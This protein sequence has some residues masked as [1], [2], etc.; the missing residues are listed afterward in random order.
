MGDFCWKSDRDSTGGNMTEEVLISVKGLHA[1]ATEDED[2]VE[3]FSAGKY[4]F[5]NGKHYI[6]YEEMFCLEYHKQQ[7]H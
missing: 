6:L 7:H 5:K 1:L 2:E 3:V 4:Y